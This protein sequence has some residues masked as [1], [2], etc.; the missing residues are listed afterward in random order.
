MSADQKFKIDISEKFP[1]LPHAPIVEAIIEIRAR[2]EKGWEESAVRSYFEPKLSSYAYLDAQRFFEHQVK[3]QVGQAPEQTLKDLGLKGVRFQSTDKLHIVQLNR[4]GFA[5]SRL[6]PYADWDQLSKEAMR[7]C[8]IYLEFAR[9]TEVQ[10]IGVRFINRIQLSLGQVDL[11]DYIQRGPQPPRAL[12]VPFAGF[13]HYDTLGIPGYSYAINVIRT[14]QVS[15]QPQKG[16]A[17]LILDIDVFTT[18]PFDLSA[19]AVERRLPEMRWLK[20]K[21]FFGSVTD[22]TLKTFQ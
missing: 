21:V 20:N 12:D 13:M 18:H 15:P 1:H 14:I 11:D 3:M 22:Q 5:F 6:Q 7:L 2:A 9:P 19:G 17:A 16:G 10:R 8:H 4:D